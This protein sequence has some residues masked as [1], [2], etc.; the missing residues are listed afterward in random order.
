MSEQNTPTFQIQRVYVK[1]A[2]F[3]S[4]N[5]PTIFKK[6]W[7]PQVNL[8]MNTRAVTL[9]E[10]TYEVTLMLTVTAKIGEDV[11]FIA[12]IQQAGIFTIAHF[13][14][15]TVNQMLAAYAPNIL[16][17][18][19]RTTIDNMIVQGSFPAIMLAPINFD[20]LY[21][22][23]LADEK[24]AAEKGEAASEEPESETTQH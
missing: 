19:A 20:G 8:D 6:P 9:E 21:Q 15:E 16:F 17:P 14:Q 22:Q 5:S 1:D 4:P 3:E 7:E 11:A 23:R 10:N 12:E 24:E 2:S 18:Y 13:P